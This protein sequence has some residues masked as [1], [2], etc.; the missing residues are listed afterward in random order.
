MYYSLLGRD[1]ERDI[2][3][4]MRR[5]GLGMTIWSPLAA[6]FLTGKYTR[7]SLS[8]PDNRYSGFD[9]LPFD[10]EFGF[11]LVERLRVV[12]TKHKASVAQVAIAWLLAREAVSSVLIGATK[13]H[14]LEDNLG[15]I[16]VKLSAEEIAE[17]DALTPPPPVYP[18]WFIDKMTDQVTAEAI[19]VK[20]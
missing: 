3:P 9:L 19:G 16:D 4:M 15:A 8:D 6:G 18:N 2:V 20:R 12:A 1:V 17:L 7:E 10:K 11:S 13:L 14:Q 5:Y